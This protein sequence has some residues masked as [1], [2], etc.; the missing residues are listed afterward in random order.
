MVG[1]E[2]ALNVTCVKSRATAY[3]QVS[4]N[5]VC[6]VSGPERRQ[7]NTKNF[8]GYYSDYSDY[9][10]SFSSLTLYF[11][12]HF[13]QNISNYLEDEPVSPAPLYDTKATV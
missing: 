8:L 7:V 6:R 2:S 3:I 4:N 12:W 9:S 10:R 1:A 13:T 5:S 11:S